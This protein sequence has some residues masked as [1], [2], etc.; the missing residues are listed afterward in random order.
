MIYL[1]EDKTPIKC[2]FIANFSTM[3]KIAE[4]FSPTY[5]APEKIK[6]TYKVL[7]KLAKLPN[8]VFGQRSKI[9][10]KEENYYF[11]YQKPNLLFLGLVNNQYPEIFI[12]ELISN[13]FYKDMPSMIEESD[14]E[15]NSYDKQSLKK[16]ID[17]YQD[18][19]KL[20]EDKYKS[21]YLN[22]DYCCEDFVY[23]SDSID[24]LKKKIEKNKNNIEN[25]IKIKRHHICTIS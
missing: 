19:N 24:S 9:T 1:S 6:L 3:K 16:L 20:Y 11:I 25:E 2:L 18:L 5:L 8:K 4:Y 7:Y 12:F 17:S 13:I 14:E 23:V 10:S 15:L 21:H 22:G